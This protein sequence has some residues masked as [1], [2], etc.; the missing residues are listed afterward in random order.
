MI[1]VAVVGAGT[2]ATRH[3]EAYAVN[4]K[5]QLV[6]V[7]DTNF[8]KADLLAK[9]FGAKAFQSYSNMLDNESIDA[10]AIATPDQFHAIMAIEAFERGKH[11]MC[12]KPLGLSVTEAKNMVNAA[13]KSNLVNMVNFTYRNAP[14]VQT[15]R[16]YVLSGKIGQIRHFSASYLQ[17]WLVSTAWGD[18]RTDASWLWR[19]STAHGSNGALFD[20]GVHLIDL[21]TFI[22][23]DFESVQCQTRCFNKALDNI[24]DQYT[25]DANDSALIIANCSNGAF[26]SL[27]LT[28]WATGHLNDITVT[29][30]GDKGAIKIDLTK[31]QDKIWICTGNNINTG[32]FRALNCPPVSNLFEQFIEAVDSKQKAEPDFATG[33]NVQRVLNACVRSNNLGV[34][35][36]I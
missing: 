27:Q 10:V 12:E 28:R 29:L 9:Q 26:G 17:S 19:L 33:L 36:K 6:A 16:E 1:K 30:H 32:R 35:D 11:V 4:P 21:V 24:I 2:M 8:L 34:I 15:A 5:C 18:W 7:C 20:I 14:A 23:G 25:L 31:S 22:A 3:A 13:K